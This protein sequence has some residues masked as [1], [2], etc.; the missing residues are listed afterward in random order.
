M[1]PVPA[2]FALLL[3]TTTAFSAADVLLVEHPEALYILDRYQQR[4]QHPSR[5][6]IVPFIPLRIV[7]ARGTL[8][9]AFTLAMR[10]ETGGETFFLLTDD[11]GGILRAAEAGILQWHRGVVMLGDTIEVLRSG[12]LRMSDPLR[13][14]SAPLAAGSR[15]RR[16]FRSGSET[17]I[18]LIDG[19]GH[20]GWAR[21]E[22]R[23]QGRLWRTPSVQPGPAGSPLPSAEARVGE[24][25]EQ[26]NQLLDSLFA[27]MNTRV[28][29]PREAPRWELRR[30]EGELTC[31]L[32]GLSDPAAMTEST[33][34]LARR[35]E[36][37]VSGS[38]FAVSHT[39][40]TIRIR[41]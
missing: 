24:L 14:S 35:I 13:R 19:A 38:G 41:P 11:A 9:D 18:R 16:E 25:L 29:T 33:A 37:A 40:G 17:Y 15:I 1:T 31:V 32:R 10:I 4:V 7:E 2:L 30:A 36:L 20:F 8:S 22:G 27:F 34:V 3:A 6:G 21:L 12:A 26:T 5:Q 28:R 23:D 39:A